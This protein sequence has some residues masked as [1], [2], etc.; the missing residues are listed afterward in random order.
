[1]VNEDLTG[2]LLAEFPSA[3]TLWNAWRDASRLNL[4]PKESDLRPRL[5]EIFE[6]NIAIMEIH[7]PDRLIGRKMAAVAVKVMGI[8]LAGQ[9]YIDLTPRHHRQPRMEFFWRVTTRPCGA[10]GKLPHVV[11]ANKRSYLM[12]NVLALP[13][14]QDHSCSVP[15]VYMSNDYEKHLHTSIF[16]SHNSSEFPPTLQADWIDLGFGVEPVDLPAIPGC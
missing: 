9:N 6:S 5:D 4:P 2:E 11:P 10:L 3:T 7:A 14:V 16:A 13:V 15:L 12:A 1:M 8:D